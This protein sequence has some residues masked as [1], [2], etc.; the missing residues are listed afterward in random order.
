MLNLAI[1]EAKDRLRIPKLWKRLGLLG[2]PASSCKSPFR[3][4]QNASFSIYDDGRRYHDHATGQDGD[5][6]DFLG[7]AC[8]LVNS[9]ACARFLDMAAMNCGP[10]PFREARPNNGEATGVKLPAL[11]Q[12]TE[13]E[14]RKLA[15]LRHLN[16]EGLSLARGRG[17]LS[18][19]VVCSYRCWIIHD[20][21]RR[22]AQARRLDGKPFPA[23]EKLAERK[24]HTLAGSR[25]FWPVGVW[26][27]VDYDLIALVEGGADLLAAFHF[28]NAGGWRDHVAAVAILGASNSISEEALKLVAGKRV[29]IFPHMD[30]A[31][32][33]AGKRWARQLH[34]VGC[35][36]D[37]FSFEGLLTANGQP[38]N[39]LNDCALISPKGMRELREIFSVISK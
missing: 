17:V 31:G 20:G 11:D 23:Y 7:E 21:E 19:G 26:Q 27:A 13:G 6:I 18:F 34:A 5:A 9:E 1:D 36:V 35:E 38:V 24:A 16:V 4:D 14:L 10:E 22:N 33:Q 39:D 37:G 29:L 30:D 25:A 15:D 28:I 3:N 32:Q 2:E 12:G 8:G